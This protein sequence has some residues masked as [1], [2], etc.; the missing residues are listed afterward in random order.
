MKKFLLFLLIVLLAGCAQNIR[1]HS[2]ETQKRTPNIS[3]EA[4]YYIEGTLDRSRAVFL[5][6]PEAPIEVSA[7]SPQITAT[8][9]TYGD[10]IA[11]M[12]EAR[13]LRKVITTYLTYKDK[14]LGY[15][16]TY[17]DDYHAAAGGTKIIIEIY[18]FGGKIHFKAAEKLEQST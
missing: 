18:E 13:G 5:R 2:M 11:Y 3:Y 1:Y 9:S 6:H 17:S 14:P 4:Y 15:L 12:N 10:A 16:I 7:S 8:T